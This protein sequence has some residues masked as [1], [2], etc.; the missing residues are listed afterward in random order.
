MRFESGLFRKP[1]KLYVATVLIS[2]TLEHER[3]PITLL[4]SYLRY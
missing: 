3:P 2:A 4:A 1:A